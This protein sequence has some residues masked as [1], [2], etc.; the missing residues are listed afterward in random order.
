[1][2]KTIKLMVSAVL[3][4]TMLVGCGST[5][6]TDSGNEGTSEA[7]SS[8]DDVITMSGSTS[9]EKLCNTLKEEYMNKTGVEIDVQFTGSGAGIQ[10]VSE[11]TVNIGN[12][13]RA[14]KD[15]EKAKGLSE[16]IVALDGIG[17][18]VDKANTV[19]DISKDNLAKVYKGEIKNWKELGGA[20]E[21][22]V[23]IGREAGSGTRGAFEEILGIEDACIYA[24]EI[25]S[26]GAVMAKVAST[27]GAI[28]YVSLDVIDDTVSTLKVDSVEAT[29]ENI[30]NGTYSIQRPFVMATKGAITEQSQTVQDFFN[31]LESEEGQTIITKLGLV[32]T[33]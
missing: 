23:V 16:N 1:M 12:S 10:A 18:I 17:I 33:K 5:G 7:A 9:M 28:G 27:P 29:A 6:T 21:P 14:L 30:K 24:Q 13:S 8:F 15:E 11:G 2:K 19:A 4:A 3:A 20:D 32:T 22:I 26:T 31:W 25:S